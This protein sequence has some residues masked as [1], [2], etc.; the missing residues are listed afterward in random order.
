MKIDYAKLEKE[1]M[2]SNVSLRELARKHNCAPSP[3]NRYAKEHEW[4][5]KRAQKVSK[6]CKNS[7]EKEI[8]AQDKSW[9]DLKSTMRQAIASEWEKLL[10]DKEQHLSA[11][12]SLTKATKDARDMGVFGATLS[13]RKLTR[14]IEAL[15]KQLS[16]DDTDKSIVVRI[17]GGDEYAQ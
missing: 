10:A 8:E 1:Y 14:E 17:E 3:I 6:R 13:E 5:Q 9:E 15:E 16:S 12:A 7:I 2:T 4:A 11:V